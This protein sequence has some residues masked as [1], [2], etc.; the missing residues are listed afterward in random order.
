M[1]STPETLAQWLT[2]AGIAAERLTVAQHAL[3]Q[4][5]FRFRQ[6]VGADYYSTRLLSHFL[7]H[8]GADLKVAQIARL[9][10]VSRPTASRQQGLSSKE[11]IQAAHHRLAGRP[12]GKLL[13]RYAG[14][15]AEFILTQTDATHYDTLDFIERTWGV[16]VS[17]VALHKFLKK[18]GLDRASRAAAAA[19]AVP[20]AAPAG[21]GATGVVPAAPAAGVPP[22]QPVPLPAPPFSSPAPT[23]PVP[24]C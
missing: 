4:A 11:V 14:P 12:H 7:L 15:I 21:G 22:G 16:R 1:A 9:L 23:T 18:Y 17:T 3:L 10:A 20:A 6:R 2:Q 19:R 5:A 13:P 24:F 8:C